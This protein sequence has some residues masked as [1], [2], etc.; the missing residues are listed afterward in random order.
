MSYKTPSFVLATLET[1]IAPGRQARLSPFVENAQFVVLTGDHPDDHNRAKSCMEIVGRNRQRI[2]KIAEHWA[3]FAQEGKDFASNDYADADF[4]DAY[5][6]YYFSANVPKVQQVLLDLVRDGR[7]SGAIDLLDVGVGTGTTAVAVLDFLLA[8]W[9]VS[10][11]YGEPFPVSDLRVVGI[12]RSKKAIDYAK[13]V[14]TAYSSALAG[15][16]KCGSPAER[17]QV[18]EDSEVDILERVSSWASRAT[19]Q[20]LDLDKASPDSK[21][22]A[23]LVVMANVWNELDPQGR[24][25]CEGLLEGMDDGAIAVII[26]PGNRTAASSLMKWRRSFCNRVPRLTSLAPCGQEFG[27]SLPEHCDDCWNLRRESFHQPYLYREFRD[28]C[29]EIVP[30]RRS[31]DEYEN[32]LLSWSY[33][34]LRKCS[35]EEAVPDGTSKHLADGE[36]IEEETELRYIGTYGSREGNTEPVCYSPDVFDARK[37]EKAWKEYLKVCPADY[38]AS[39]LAIERRPGFQVPRLRYGQRFVVSGIDVRRTAEEGVYRLVPREGAQ[40]EIRTLDSI[41]PKSTQGWSFLRAYGHNV[42]RVVDELAYRLFGFTEMWDLQHQMLSRVL[43]GKH[44]LGIAATGGGK[45]ECYIL[46]AMVLPGITIV[47]SPLKSLMADQYEQRIKRRYGLEHLVTFING[48]VR[49][50]ERQARL[51]RMELGYY[52]LVYFTP[53]QLERGYVLDSLRRADRSVGIRYLAMDEAHCI[54]QWGHDFRPSYLNILRRLQQKEVEIDLRIIALTATASPKVREDI[55]E[56]LGLNPEALE[57]DGDVFVHS[58]NRPEINLVVRVKRKTEEKVEDIL[59]QLGKLEECNRKNPS[60]GAAIVFMPHTGG[61]PENTWRYLPGPGEIGSRRGML[62]AGVTGFASFLE[63]QLGKT[64]SIYHSKMEDDAELP[65]DAMPGF[66]AHETIH[67][68]DKPLGDLTGRTRQREQDAFIRGE[69]DIMVA[70]KGFGMGIDKENIRLIMHRTPTAN[71]EA[72]A[73]EAGRAGRDGELATA[74]LFYSPDSPSEGDEGG[75]TTRVRSDHEIQSFFVGEKYVRR[76]DV[77]VMRAFLRTVGR[78]VEVPRDGEGAVDR[79]LYFTNDEAIHFFDQC[80]SNPSLAGLDR[81]YSWPPFERREPRGFES[82][83]HGAIL[84]RGHVYKCKTDYLGRILAVLYRIRPDVPRMGR[85]LAFLENVQETGACLRNPQ[86]RDWD[87][88]KDSNAH[89]GDVLRS[90]GVTHQQF[91]DALASGDLLPLARRLRMP[92]SELTALL[93]DM[94]YC[95]GRFNDLGHWQSDLLDY[96]WIEAPKFGP[97]AGLDSLSAWREY[98]GARTRAFAPLA[99]ERAKKQK[100]AH[101]SV[102]DWFNWKELTS[103]VGWEVLLGPAFG[104]QDFDTYL[105]AFMQL[106]DERQQNDWASYYR[107]LTDYVGID[108]DGGIGNW[109]KPAKCLRSVLLGYLKSYEVILD[110]NC[111]SCNSCVPDEQFDRYTV[112]QRASRVQRIGPETEELLD[113]AEGSDAT[114]PSESLI[115]DLFVAIQKEQ[116]KGRSLVQ[117]VEGWSGRLLQDTPDHRGALWIRLKLVMDELP[118]PRSEEIVHI[119]Q[120]LLRVASDADLRTIW[121]L[122]RRAREVVPDNAEIYKMQAHA[123]HRLGLFPDEEAAWRE[124]I[125]VKSGKGRPD[126]RLLEEAYRGLVALCVAGG[127]LG[128]AARHAECLLWLARLSPNPELAIQRYVRMINNWSWNRVKDEADRCLS[129]QRSAASVGVLCAWMTTSDALSKEERAAAVARCLDTGDSQLIDGL[130]LEASR[131]L[132]SH[133][134]VDA[135]VAQ[136]GLAERLAAL[137]LERPE[138]DQDVQSGLELCFAALAAGQALGKHTIR[139]VNRVLFEDERRTISITRTGAPFAGDDTQL[140]RLMAVLASEFHP[141]KTSALTRWFLVFP[142]RLHR[143]VERDVALTVLSAGEGLSWVATEPALDDLQDIVVHLLPH[144]EYTQRAHNSWLAICGHLAERLAEYVEV[145]LSM[146]PPRSK[147]AEEAFDRLL[148]TRDDA[149]IQVYLRSIRSAGVGEVPER[150]KLGAVFFQLMRDHLDVLGDA[151]YSVDDLM[152][153]ELDLQAEHDVDRCDMYVAAIRAFRWVLDLDDSI[154]LRLEALALCRARRFSEV[155]QLDRDH[156][157][158]LVGPKQEPLPRVVERFRRSGPERDAASQDHDYSR[159]MESSFISEQ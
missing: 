6:A 17:K 106:H 37:S 133:L 109:R 105:E 16:V 158:L 129:D 36:G 135:A 86:M 88:T 42:R 2:S 69:R 128:D 50:K 93:S 96:W 117:Y 130:T 13:R 157:G 58:S 38:R 44:L 120:V 98:A 111:L 64:V 34:V 123:C 11:L 62:S 104:G 49:F 54:S 124:V 89:F 25:N 119:A 70:T 9:Q 146:V 65:G 94:K 31:F 159:I 29:C 3:A 118:E 77:V 141:S 43:T 145:C 56:E 7:L 152:R 5:L 72:Y 78:S 30:D 47:V 116:E 107:L 87:A 4:L 21:F 103:P 82:G 92:V 143:L 33:V 57:N 46:P 27:T 40:T 132:L 73:Q 75:G 26:E 147:C 138:E 102:D 121:P 142:A 28:G 19:W 79:Y 113:K 101:R 90:S 114:F 137:P 83:E 59:A 155:S 149:Y 8:W 125:S 150:I 15:K 148:E 154:V 12:D 85:R 48:D 136:P 80:T 52:K 67:D 84:D 71:L 1:I 99:W 61:N 108:T 18:G 127:P 55:C 32:R 63:R 23:N 153:L 122:L 140:S 144:D 115:A 41:L 35:S 39:K 131:L 95:E 81:P 22:Q 24:S 76:E 91:Q 156:P 66:S 20:H 45:S 151:P 110:G 68:N 97:A 10:A 112:D 126:D 53:E 14:V 100:R 139:S 51:K 60:P 74:I 134:G